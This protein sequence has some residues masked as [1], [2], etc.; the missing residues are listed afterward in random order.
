MSKPLVS[1]LIPAFNSG[2][3][4]QRS[5]SSLVG[6]TVDNWEAVLVDDGSTDDTWSRS[7]LISDDRIRRFRLPS[8]VGRGAARQFALDHSTG[9][10]ICMLDADDWYYPWKLES[11]LEAMQAFPEATLVT[12]SMASVRENGELA[13]IWRGQVIP[14]PE[15]FAPQFK[16]LIDMSFPHGPSMIRATAAR[17]FA[18]SNQLRR[19]EEFHYLARV[20]RGERYRVSSCV[21]YCYSDERSFQ[22]EGPVSRYLWSARAS[23]KLIPFYP[24]SA[25]CLAIMKIM[26]GALSF[27]SGGK[28]IGKRT[29][30][31]APTEAELAEFD[32]ARKSIEG[33]V[34]R[35]QSE[36]LTRDVSSA[37]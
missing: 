5:L 13:G 23:F 2:T 31:S 12:S 25:T 4:I 15:R 17:A 6:Q 16:S 24:A 10:F 33:I 26:Q 3:T 20:M 37:S 28:R 35:S 18:Y 19:A 29:H 34:G 32:L 30:P 14:H 21:L 27:I 8:N 1:V 9:L 11:Q 36:V 22:G 7:L